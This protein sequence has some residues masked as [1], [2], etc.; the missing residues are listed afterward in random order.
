MVRRSAGAG[1]AWMA[2]RVAGMSLGGMAGRVAGVELVIM[3]ALLAMAGCRSVPTAELQVGTPRSRIQQVE[4]EDR[5]AVAI[6]IP[7]RANPDGAEF[8]V[9]RSGRP[10]TVQST[11]SASLPGWI[12]LVDDTGSFATTLAYQIVA[13]FP[14]GDTVRKELSVGLARSLLAFP[15]VTLA[16]KSVTPKFVWNTQGLEHARFQLD[17]APDSAD[18]YSLLFPGGVSS[19]DWRDPATSSAGNQV[20]TPRSLVVGIRYTARVTATAGPAERQEQMVSRPI[21]F[22]P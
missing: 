11:P 18:G 10:V 7:V 16:R 12:D 20:I 4:G 9:M 13:T 22:T 19:Y 14:T 15:S 1:L 8:A 6:T 17:V 5:V 2:G 21:A 3:A